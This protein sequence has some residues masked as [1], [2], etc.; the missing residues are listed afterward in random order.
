MHGQQNIKISNFVTYKHKRSACV[1]TTLQ[2]GRPRHR[3]SIPGRENWIFIGY[4]I[5]WDEGTAFF[6]NVG[7]T[8]PNPASLSIKLESLH[9][10]FPKASGLILQP[11]EPSVEWLK[12]ELLRGLERAER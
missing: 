9:F 6:R 7:N 5:F 10:L 1:A 12:V 8:H 3:G 11:I 2:S 4:L